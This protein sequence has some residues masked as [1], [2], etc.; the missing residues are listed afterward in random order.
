VGAP[1]KRDSQE[2]P[3]LSSWCLKPYI[4]HHLMEQSFEKD[5]LEVTSPEANRIGAVHEKLKR[6]G[7]TE[8]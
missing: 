4:Y 1:R 6:T 5:T 8:R 7:N 2:S 3:L